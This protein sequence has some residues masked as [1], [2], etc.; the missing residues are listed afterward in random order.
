MPIAN[1]ENNANGKIIYLHPKCE[2]CIAN[3]LFKNKQ[4]LF[5]VK[6]KKT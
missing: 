6:S 5:C 4:D 3:R 2:N 1:F